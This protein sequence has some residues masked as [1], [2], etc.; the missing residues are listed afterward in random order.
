MDLNIRKDARN[1]WLYDSLDILN[2]FDAPLSF[3]G[4]S[5]D[6][7]APLANHNR[8]MRAHCAGVAGGEPSRGQNLVMTHCV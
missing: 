4:I 8:G 5:H 1:K 2:I 6:E 7:R 3:V